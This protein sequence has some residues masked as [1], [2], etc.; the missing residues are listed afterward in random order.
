MEDLHINLHLL[1][2]VLL[3]LA[4]VHHDDDDFVVDVD[5]LRV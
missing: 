1:A 5:K 4:P 3:G 2:C